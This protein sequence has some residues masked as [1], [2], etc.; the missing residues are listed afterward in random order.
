MFP[1][2]GTTLLAVTVLVAAGGVPI[3][4]VEPSCRDVAARASPVGSMEICMR[5]EQQARDRLLGDRAQ[6]T[7]AERSDCVDL[8]TLA[9]EPSYV[10]LLT[11]LEL[12]RDARNLQK[13][14]AA[15]PP[16]RS[17]N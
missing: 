14:D 4:N 6:F 17:R 8:A 3:F 16:A 5:K 10:A 11:C 1:G 15:A 9:D 12:R 2:I 13:R 7:P